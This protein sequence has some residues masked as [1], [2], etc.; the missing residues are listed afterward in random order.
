MVLDFTKQ[1]YYDKNRKHIEISTN[2]GYM[3]GDFS[4][5]QQCPLFQEIGEEEL[6][7]LLDCLGMRKKQFEKKEVIAAEGEPAQD[8]GI[9]LS[10]QVQVE[11]TDYFGNRSILTTLESGEIFGETFACAD[12][13]KLPVDV[14][15]AEETTVLFVDCK[16]ILQPCSHACSFHQK[17]IYNLMEVIAAKNFV[18]QQKIQVTSKRTTREK[19]MTYLNLQAKRA[20]S[21]QFDL[22]YDR[23]ELADY[24]G[25]ERS[26]LSVEI[27]KLKK[28]GILE[29]EKRHF[30]LL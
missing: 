15:A 1:V 4:I 9:V 29:A 18:L 16:Q 23:Q 13:K 26:G 7:G 8:I 27:S 3:K 20:G 6:E 17:M 11:Q 12:V 2:G 22:P 24:L 5:L 30:K 19:L 25:V 14:V 28:E 21:H 10:G